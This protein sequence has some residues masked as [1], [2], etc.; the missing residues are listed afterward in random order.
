MKKKLVIA[1]IASVL[2]FLALYYVAEFN[3]Y[4]A[5]FVAIGASILT[6]IINVTKLKSK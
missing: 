2:M 4:N 6:Y 1:L 3:I 5:L